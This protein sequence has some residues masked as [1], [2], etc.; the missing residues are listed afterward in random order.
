MNILSIYSILKYKMIL[1][2]AFVVNQ[3]S[4]NGDPWPHPIIIFIIASGTLITI[5]FFFLLIL[6]LLNYL[7]KQVEENWLPKEQQKDI[8]SSL[9][10]K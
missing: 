2:I 3:T 4:T 10:Q 7:I 9:E 1:F 5:A 6:L 8:P